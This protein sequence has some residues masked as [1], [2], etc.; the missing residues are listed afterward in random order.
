ML[1]LGRGSAPAC[2]KDYDLADFLCVWYAK[3][4]A[5]W[6]HDTICCLI[7]DPMCLVATG[8]CCL[9]T[10]GFL[11]AG[12]IFCQGPAASRVLVSRSDKTGSANSI[13][14]LSKAAS[15]SSVL[16]EQ[17]TWVFV[18]WT[19]SSVPVSATAIDNRSRHTIPLYSSRT[20]L[21]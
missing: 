20:A 21:T 3:N 2:V 4:D 17:V 10:S 18:H 15:K 1:I 7:A 19:P 11:C 8:N 12:E 13:D 14:H 16:S 6:R 9:G 5:Q